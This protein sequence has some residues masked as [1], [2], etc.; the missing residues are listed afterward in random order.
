MYESRYAEG[1]RSRGGEAHAHGSSNVEQA[2]PAPLYTS[3]T[4]QARSFR[5]PADA[6]DAENVA[7]RAFKTMSSHSGAAPAN[8]GE[9][10]HGRCAAPQRVPQP[11]R[12]PPFSSLPAF[13]RRSPPAAFQP[14]ATARG[15]RREVTRPRAPDHGLRQREAQPRAE[16][17]L[18][19][20]AHAFSVFEFQPMPWSTAEQRPRCLA[21]PRSTLRQRV[22]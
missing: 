1:I 18:C 6:A 5:Q 14:S 12:C 15:L 4:V 22:A 16:R 2:V 10:G 20:L 21:M 19:S 8:R 9:D 17:S 3:V 11:R 7:A 13:R